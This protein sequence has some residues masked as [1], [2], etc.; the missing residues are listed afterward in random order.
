[1]EKIVCILTRFS[2]ITYLAT[3]IRQSCKCYDYG[4]FFPSNQQWQ[5]DLILEFSRC[6]LVDGVQPDPEKLSLEVAT[7]LGWYGN[8]YKMSEPSFMPFCVVNFSKFENLRVAA[9]H[10]Q[11]RWPPLTIN[12]VSKNGGHLYQ[13]TYGGHLSWSTTVAAS[14]DQLS[15]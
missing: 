5:N 15:K 9:S 10:D 3:K 7:A 4:D 14:H 1:M 13:S 2:R 8:I 12:L 6:R 11:L